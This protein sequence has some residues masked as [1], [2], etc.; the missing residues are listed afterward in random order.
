MEEQSSI[1]LKSPDFHERCFKREGPIGLFYLFFSRSCLENIRSWSLVNLDS[2]TNNI[3]GKC[4]S[5][6]FN[7]SAGLE[8]AMSLIQMHSIEEYWQVGKFS[9][10]PDFKNVMSHQH[11]QKIRA[12]IKLH[13]PNEDRHKGDPL[14]HTRNISERVLEECTSVACPTGPIAFDKSTIQT[15]ART[16][17]KRF[18]PNKPQKYGIHLCLLCGW[19]YVYCYNFSPN[20]RGCSN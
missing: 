5:D 7:A 8:M 16:S 3:K 18:I 20:W 11:F 13:P 10:H 2:L 14:W 6:M 4:R 17:A 19:K 9:G 15:K 12:S 1:H